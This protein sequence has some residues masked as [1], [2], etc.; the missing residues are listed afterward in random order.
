MRY[1]KF[2]SEFIPVDNVDTIVNIFKYSK[3][4]EL[5]IYNENHEWIEY[6]LKYHRKNGQLFYTHS[7]VWYV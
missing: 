3:V 7:S 2:N 6:V 5:P 4:K 1:I